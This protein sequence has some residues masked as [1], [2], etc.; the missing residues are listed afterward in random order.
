MKSDLK[1][2]PFINFEIILKS[3]FKKGSPFLNLAVP[4]RELGS[5]WTAEVGCCKITHKEDSSLKKV[6][7]EFGSFISKGETIV[8][9]D[10]LFIQSE[11]SIILKMSDMSRTEEDYHIFLEQEIKMDL[12]NFSIEV[13]W[14]DYE[15]EWIP[16]DD[17][18]YYNGMRST[19]EKELINLSRKLDSS[20][21]EELKKVKF[22]KPLL[23][24]WFNQ[25]SKSYFIN[26][27]FNIYEKEFIIKKGEEK[28]I[29][30]PDECS[31]DDK[32][33][34]CRTELCENIVIEKHCIEKED[35]FITEELRTYYKHKLKESISYEIWEEC[36]DIWTN[37]IKKTTNYEYQDN[38]LKMIIETGKDNTS[39]KTLDIEYDVNIPI[40]VKSYNEAVASIFTFFIICE[41]PHS[42]QITGHVD[43]TGENIYFDDHPFSS[44]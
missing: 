11:N 44:M 33:S 10:W 19:K 4:L 2:Q 12:H 36:P 38:L 3:F 1:K 31:L 13:T 8:I 17:G 29:L 39:V 26:E 18:E 5:T 43:S 35:Y 37:S 15:E 27:N 28:T 25:N 32:I 34:I 23:I 22:F 6:L 7:F 20:D 16:Q 40:M 30:T 42:Y 9:P 21:Y 14:Q 41:K 24:E